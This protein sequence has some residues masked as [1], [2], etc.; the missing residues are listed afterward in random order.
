MVR[1]S[2]A[3]LD[4]LEKAHL[5][6]S[7]S[8]RRRAS[9]GHP[10]CQARCKRPTSFLAFF[11]ALR[12]AHEGKEGSWREEVCVGG[13]KEVCVCGGKRCA[14]V[15]GG[16]VRVCM[17]V[18][19]S[20]LHFIIVIFY[21]CI[22]NLNPDPMLHTERLSLLRLFKGISILTSP[23]PRHDLRFLSLCHGLLDRMLRESF[24]SLPLLTPALFFSVC[25]HDSRLVAPNNQHE[26]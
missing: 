11:L 26:Q 5:D 1:M 18:S 8:A 10:D 2:E 21:L 22:I 25:H 3:L 6:V 9:S 15:E 16:G 24:L 4:D 14:C 17:M 13:G 20:R 19:V 23:Q 12:P 7:E